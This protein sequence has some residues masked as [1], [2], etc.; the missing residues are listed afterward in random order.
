MQYYK[1]QMGCM[2]ILLYIAF[3]YWKE[4]GKYH[5]KH[6]LRIFD[7]LLVVGIISVLFD[8]ITAHTVNHPDVVAPMV[9]MICHMFFLLSLDTLIFLLFLYM[10]A[11]TEGIPKP[12]KYGMLLYIPYILN[13]LVVVV[14]MPQLKYHEGEISN[15][16]MGISAYTC[17]IMAGVY[18]LLSWVTFFKR[19]K[20]IERHKRFGIFTYLAVLFCVTTFQM[21]HPQA[22]LS[23][24]AVTTIIIGV[25]INQENPVIEELSR[26]HKE[27]VMG[28]A[29]LV[30]NKDGSTGGHI[31]RTSLYVKLLAE[32]LRHRGFY[33]DVLTKD[34][35]NNLCRS[36]PMHDIGKVSV[37]DVILQKPGKLTDEEFEAMKQHAAKG[38]EI[39]RETFGHLENKEFT[40]MAYEVSRYHHEKWNGKGYPDGLKRKEIPLCARIMAIADVFDAVSMKRCYREALPLDKCFEIIQEGSGQDFEPLLAEVFLDIR[41]K[42]EAAHHEVNN[43]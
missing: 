12:K 9:N 42:V 33:K 24:I 28:F 40:Q 34:Y 23:S 17:F 18:I 27:M 21:I 13:V 39:I 43:L 14:F 6:K 35:I 37:P 7:Y 8:G 22:L 29:T 32:E 31:K 19:W 38:G 5:K 15:Y 10:R 25:Y 26:Y 1:L 36:A 20:Y 2:M 30:E 3:L 16:S 11:I 41:D 4:R